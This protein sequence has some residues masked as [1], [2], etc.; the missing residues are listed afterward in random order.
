MLEFFSWNQFHEIFIHKKIFL[1]CYETNED[2][3]EP[4]K[5]CVNCWDDPTSDIC[6]KDCIVGPGPCINENK[7]K[8]GNCIE[9]KKL[10]LARADKC[11]VCAEA[12]G[13]D[14][15]TVSFYCTI[16]NVSIY[17]GLTKKIIML[18]TLFL[19]N[20]RPENA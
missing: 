15:N 6:K 5:H 8:V 17:I 12:C 3:H 7:I 1:D 14:Q 20:Y 18:I 19:A 11:L 16:K 4:L 13:M 2:C 9:G 10:A